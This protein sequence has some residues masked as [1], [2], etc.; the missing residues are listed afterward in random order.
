MLVLRL[1][2][3]EGIARCCEGA[4]D[5]RCGDKNKNKKEESKLGQRQALV[6]QTTNVSVARFFLLWPA[7]LCVSA[8]FLGQ[9]GK[10][11]VAATETMLLSLMVDTGKGEEGVNCLRSRWTRSGA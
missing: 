11:V 7:I 4:G 2:C 1:P 10:P 6:K 3:I 5:W 8:L 9:A